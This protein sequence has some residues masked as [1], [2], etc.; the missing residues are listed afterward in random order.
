[1]K[2]LGSCNELRKRYNLNVECCDS[3]H[4]EYDEGYDWI[5]VNTTEGW[6]FVCCTVLNAYE[7]KLEL[8][9]DR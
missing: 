7:E 2:Y 3:C 4:E 6:Y 1:M 5:E 9:L 8:L